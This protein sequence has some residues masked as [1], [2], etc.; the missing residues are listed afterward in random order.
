MIYNRISVRV[1]TFLLLLHRLPVTGI[2]KKF[3]FKKNF[4]KCNHFELFSYFSKMSKIHFFALTLSKLQKKNLQLCYSVFS[5]SLT[6]VYKKNCVD[7]SRR[8]KNYLDSD[9]KDTGQNA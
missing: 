5:R 4:F 1:C 2:Q 6:L 9:Q 3:F 7:K 8:S